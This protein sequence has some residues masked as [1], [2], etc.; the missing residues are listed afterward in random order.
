MELEELEK[1]DAFS[2]CILVVPP[3]F[4]CSKMPRPDKAK[5]K[6]LFKAMDNVQK[7]T[8]DSNLIFQQDGEI[9]A[10]GCNQDSTGYSVVF[11]L[12]IGY[13]ISHSIVV[14]NLNDL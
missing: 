3:K 12:L 7:D 5:T 2:K 9:M 6:A 10:F 1:M 4:D 14:R 11:D 8:Q 13:R